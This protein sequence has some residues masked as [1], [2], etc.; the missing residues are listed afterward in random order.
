M[1]QQHIGDYPAAGRWELSPAGLESQSGPLSRRVRSRLYPTHVPL[2]ALQKGAVAV[3][4]AVGAALRCACVR[5][6]LP[7]PWK[8]WHKHA[9]A[10]RPQR[11]DLVA[12]V[13]ETTGGPGRQLRTTG[14]LCRLTWCCL[15]QAMQR[16]R[17]C[18][19]ACCAAPQGARSWRS[20]RSSR[21]APE[22][23]GLRSSAAC[24]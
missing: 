13:G 21:Y 19:S 6:G 2:N 22:T 24:S 8:P 12:A 16:F 14:A 17:Q 18:G 1:Q 5:A 3:L 23:G 7:L 9:P 20:S 11:A 4:S 10:R 15:A